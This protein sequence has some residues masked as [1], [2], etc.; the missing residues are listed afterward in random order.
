MDKFLQELE[1]WQILN[2]EIN[3]L[4]LD[5]KKVL[6]RPEIII[7][8]CHWMRNFVLLQ[9]GSGILRKLNSLLQ[10]KK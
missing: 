2:L 7:E 5:K 1:P 8:A 3:C 10:R 9:K 6:S 4:P